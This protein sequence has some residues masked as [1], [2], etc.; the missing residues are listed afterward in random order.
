MHLN[1]ASAQTGIKLEDQKSLE[2]IFE[3]YRNSLVFHSGNPF[4]EKVKLESLASL[5]NLLRHEISHL[6]N[7]GI[8]VVDEEM[9]EAF[10]RTEID[11]IKVSD[12]HL[13]FFS[14]ELAIPESICE[15]FGIAPIIVYDLDKVVSSAVAMGE[16]DPPPMEVRGKL[17]YSDVFT[18]YTSIEGAFTPM[19]HMHKKTDLIS[20]IEDIIPELKEFTDSSK[21]KHIKNGQVGLWSE[22][23]E[24]SHKSWKFFMVV[25]LYLQSKDKEK[26][27]EPV[28]IKHLN[29][30]TE[31][32]GVKRMRKKCKSY[33]LVN[34]LPRKNIKYIGSTGKHHA[35]PE[36]HWVKGSMRYYN[37]EC[38]HRNAD[39]SVKTAWVLPYP[40]GNGKEKL[41]MR[42]ERAL[43]T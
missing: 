19:Y 43:T 11:G 9:A 12:I 27:L 14:V 32:A 8:I 16:I 5:T 29:Q 1:Q 7:G 31:S 30:N 33:K 22:M 23:S 28:S 18:S 3:A 39:G 37:H 15:R 25:M 42:A 21:E 4:V 6:S 2:K 20:N 24:I 36:S 17:Q 38:F 34:I 35:S 10:A 41:D 40:R 26:A 13:P